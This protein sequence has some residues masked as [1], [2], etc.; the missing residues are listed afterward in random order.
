[1]PALASAP[2]RDARR[3]CK[4]SDSIFPHIRSH[5]IELELVVEGSEGNKSLVGSVGSDPERKRPLRL[6]MLASVWS[7]W[8]NS[9]DDQARGNR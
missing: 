4:P 2:V 8:I 1:M 6:L 3:N 5:R 9:L 7:G